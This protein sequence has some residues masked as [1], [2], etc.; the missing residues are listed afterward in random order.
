[1]EESSNGED[2]WYKNW[3]TAL[4]GALGWGEHRKIAPREKSARVLV[5]GGGLELAF[6][7]SL[8]AGRYS[9]VLRSA[10]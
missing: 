6:I 9:Y 10:E 5:Y 7:R 1:M 2:D 4:L 3:A 8:T